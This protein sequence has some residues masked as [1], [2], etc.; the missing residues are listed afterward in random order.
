MLVP[1]KANKV[2]AVKSEFTVVHINA[3]WNRINDISIPKI[4]NCTIRYAFLED[5]SENMKS[6]VRY[7]PTVVLYKGNR[8]VHQWSADLSFKLELTRQDIEDAIN[9]F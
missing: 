6:T 2:K 4:P 7:V 5:Q 8:A 1:L 3:K 9:R